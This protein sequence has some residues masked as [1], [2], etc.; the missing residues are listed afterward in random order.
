MLHLPFGVLG[1]QV[2]KYVLN[3]IT[4]QSGVLD[5]NKRVLC[6]R[7]SDIQW[8]TGQI[9]STQL[10]LLELGVSIRIFN[11]VLLRLK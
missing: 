4:S 6:Y 10:V 9:V 1:Y 8:E 5:R 3:N 11:N 2:E 7:S